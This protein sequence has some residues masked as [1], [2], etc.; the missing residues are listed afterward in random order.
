MGV[1]AA[2]AAAEGIRDIVDEDA[3][4][5]AAVRASFV[6]QS[7][8]RAMHAANRV[9]EL[10]GK[11][12][13]LAFGRF[14]TSDGDHS[15]VGRLSVFDGDETLLV[16]WRAHA[17]VPFYRATPLDRHGVRSRRQFR[18]DDQGVDG[19]LIGYSDEPLDPDVLTDGS[20]LR[21]EAAVLAAMNAPRQRRNEAGRGDD[22]GRAGCDHPG[23]GR[24]T[25]DRPGW[26]G[27]RQDGRRIAPGRCTCCTTNGKS[28]PTRVSSSSARRAAS[29]AM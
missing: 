14:T 19:E 12:N 25:L 2:E 1:E 11:G 21:G 6:R 10:E 16:D 22:P 9:R 13:A 28:C 27:H 23:A 26:A 17:A 7:A 20:T 24:P 4:A 8:I 18:Y 5:D 29:F 15:Y 3:E